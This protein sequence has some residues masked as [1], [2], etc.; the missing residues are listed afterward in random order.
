MSIPFTYVYDWGKINGDWLPVFE[1]FAANN[2]KH[3]VFTEDMVNRIAGHAPFRRTLAQYM[4]QC[5]L[6]FVDGHAPFEAEATLSFPPWLY[7]LFLHALRA[8]PPQYS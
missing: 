6:D 5:K 7:P 2:A 1:D 3:L 4:D 8:S